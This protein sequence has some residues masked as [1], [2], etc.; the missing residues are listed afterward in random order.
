MKVY[1]VYLDQ[2]V[3]TELRV[4]KIRERDSNFAN[5]FEVLKRTEFQVI[6]SEYTLIEI[7]KVKSEEFVIEHLNVLNMLNAIYW[8]NQFP[9]K[10][11]DSKRVYKDYFESKNS[12][13]YQRLDY[14]HKMLIQSLNGI[15]TGVT[16]QER[17]D[18][19]VDELVIT[20]FSLLSTKLP[21]LKKPIDKIGKKIS[22]YASKKLNPLNDIGNYSILNLIP[23]LR[24]IINDPNYADIES[25]LPKEVFKEVERRL[26]NHDPNLSFLLSQDVAGTENKIEFLFLLLNWIDYYR[27][28]F[29]NITSKKGLHDA[30]MLDAKHASLAWH[31][32]FIISTDE[33][34]IKKAQACYYF[35]GSKAQVVS[36]EEFLEVFYRKNYY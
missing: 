11:P 35:I 16:A 27:D 15:D 23:D 10:F 24:E 30:S 34:F 3:L 14:K 8:N 17:F 1:T 9:H 19:F 4:S 31:F 13:L 28:R 6:Y 32:D 21:I 29:Q 18:S 5:L 22:Q 20:P 36:V 12:S 2:N 25:Y 33:K 7:N 26:F